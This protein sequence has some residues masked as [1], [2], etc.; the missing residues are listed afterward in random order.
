MVHDNLNDAFYCEV[1]ETVSTVF[2]M[3]VKS[4]T[5]VSICTMDINN[6]FFVLN[7]GIISYF[8]SEKSLS[9]KQCK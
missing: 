1:A 6:V 7:Y 4:S 2:C 9:N 3:Y 5:D 8:S